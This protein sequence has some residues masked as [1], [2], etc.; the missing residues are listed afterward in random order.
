M[1]FRSKPSLLVKHT[2]TIMHNYVAYLFHSFFLHTHCYRCTHWAG[3]S[4]PLLELQRGKWIMVEDKCT[5][6]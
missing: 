3:C 2:F 4:S 6:K 1:F 5:R